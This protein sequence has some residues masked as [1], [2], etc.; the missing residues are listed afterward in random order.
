MKELKEWFTARPGQLDQMTRCRSHGDQREDF[1]QQ[2]GHCEEVRSQGVEHVFAFWKA[3]P[4][5]IDP[6]RPRHTVL[7]L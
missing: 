3:M 1:M 6:L 5:S 7:Y 2:V 4:C